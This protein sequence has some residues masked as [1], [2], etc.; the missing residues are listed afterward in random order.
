MWS[1]EGV[2]PVAGGNAAIACVRSSARRG[3]R[4]PH[5]SPP[6]APVNPQLLATTRSPFHTPHSAFRTPPS[7]FHIFSLL[8]ATYCANVRGINLT[9]PTATYSVRR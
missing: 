3:D 9:P 8:L 6:P 1:G 5:P 2:S 4:R 7:P